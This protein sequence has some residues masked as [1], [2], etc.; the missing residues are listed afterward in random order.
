MP[1]GFRKSWNRRWNRRVA[2]DAGF[3]VLC[4]AVYVGVKVTDD[5]SD[6]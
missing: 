5:I 4:H 3:H 6:E 1:T 2:A